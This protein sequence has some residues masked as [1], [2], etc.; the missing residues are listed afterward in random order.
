MTDQL[1]GRVSLVFGATYG[2]GAAIAAKLAEHGSEVALSARKPS[3]E[4]LSR[5]RA[6]GRRAEFFPGDLSSWPQVKGVVEATV[7]AFG[8]LDV[9]VVSGRPRGTSSKLFLET[10]PESFIEFFRTR[11]VSRFYAARAAAEVMKEQGEGRIIFLTSDAG[12]TP[13]P[14]E[15]LDGASA[16][17]VVFGTRAIARELSRHGIRVNTV[18]LTLTR[19]TPAYSRF[20]EQ[21]DSNSVL[22]R[23]F[24]KIES[25]TPFGLNQPDDIAELVLFLAGDGARQI[26][27]ATISVNGG[28]SFPG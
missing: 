15:A 10:D 9:V 7:A 12:R 19:D 4:A 14:A 16:A 21:P 20:T 25:R 1:E 27:G 18:S 2:I 6:Q 22:W 23:A 13:T 11:T 26:T 17:A 24:Q 28:L 8:R 3:L 5:V